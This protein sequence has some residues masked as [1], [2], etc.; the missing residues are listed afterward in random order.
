MD[1]FLSGL[2][3]GGYSKTGY[4]DGIT[5]LINGKFLPHCTTVYPNK[6]LITHFTKKRDI[7]AS[8]VSNLGGKT[9]QLLYLL[10]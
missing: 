8:K 6:I 7:R 1:K 5:I 10:K 3:K 2:N 4:A 9:I